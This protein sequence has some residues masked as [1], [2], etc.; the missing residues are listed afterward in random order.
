LLTAAATAPSTAACLSTAPA[1]ALPWGSLLTAA[2]PTGLSSLSSGWLLT[3]A[4]TGL[5]CLSSGWL[6][7]AAAL[8]TDG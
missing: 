3:A 2:A 4:P 8:C 1:G 7:T 6:L 5:S